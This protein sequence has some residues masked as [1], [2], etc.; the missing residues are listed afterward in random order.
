MQM[1]FVAL[2]EKH[3]LKVTLDF[4]YRWIVRY[5]WKKQTVTKE[6]RAFPKEERAFPMLIHRFMIVVFTDHTH[7]IF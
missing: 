3:Q 2:R 1:H 6:E 7:L 5:I 4:T